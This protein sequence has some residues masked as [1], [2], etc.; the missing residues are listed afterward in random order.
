MVDGGWAGAMWVSVWVCGGMVG[1][2][3]GRVPMT[4]GRHMGDGSKRQ[5]ND[6]GWGGGAVHH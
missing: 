5:Q 3:G 4:L 1:W 6:S 2:V